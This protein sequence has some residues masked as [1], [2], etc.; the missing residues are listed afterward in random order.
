MI[1]L[2]LIMHHLPSNNLFTNSPAYPPPLLT[3][4]L[5][6][7]TGSNNCARGFWIILL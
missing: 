6:T 3:R 4:H 2:S 1:H 7:P 5:Y